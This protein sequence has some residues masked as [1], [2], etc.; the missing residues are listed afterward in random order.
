[1]DIYGK[2]DELKQTI[3]EL[4]LLAAEVGVKNWEMTVAEVVAISDKISREA[5]SSLVEKGRDTFKK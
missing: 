5:I 4:K 2:Y 1:M 3:A